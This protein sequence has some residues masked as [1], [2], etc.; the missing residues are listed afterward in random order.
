M[1]TQILLFGFSQIFLIPF[2][3]YFCLK[4][5]FQMARRRKNKSKAQVKLPKSRFIPAPLSINDFYND[6]L[7]LVLNRLKSEET[8]LIKLVCK[9][10]YSVIKSDRNMK[11]INVLEH[12]VIHGHLGIIKWFK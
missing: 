11:L 2:F 3:N 1:V 10:W 6:A 9:K 12:Y 7:L 4:F 5:F 8:F